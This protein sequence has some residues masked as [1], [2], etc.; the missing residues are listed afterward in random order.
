MPWSCDKEGIK[1]KRASGGSVNPRW[2]L[3]FNGCKFHCILWRS[4]KTFSCGHRRP[5]RWRCWGWWPPWGRPPQR[6]V[7]SQ[8]QRPWCWSWRKYPWGWPGGCPGPHP[9]SIP[10]PAGPRC[11]WSQCRRWCRGKSLS[12]P[13][14][15]HGPPP[16]RPAQRSWW[17]WRWC[18]F[19]R[20][21]SR[22]RRPAAPA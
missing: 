11:P 12:P 15:W 3:Y 2:P 13:T 14:P 8:T 4:W 20:H 1:R 6:C 19:C 22:H 10:P 21:S 9:A 7:S 5:E 18:R 16:Q 17:R